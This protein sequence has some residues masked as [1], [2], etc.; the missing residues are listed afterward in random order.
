LKGHETAVELDL[1]LGL[2]GLFGI[3]EC[4]L[5][6]WG[7]GAGFLVISGV[8]YACVLGALA[9]PSLASMWGYLPPAGGLSFCL[10]FFDIFQLTDQ[11]DEELDR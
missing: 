6:S 4:Y 11:L 3:G 9:I 10:Q 8:L 7:R 2:V 1:W 5:G